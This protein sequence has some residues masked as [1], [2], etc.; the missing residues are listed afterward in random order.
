MS[1]EERGGERGER[2]GRRMEEVMKFVLG[3]HTSVV[4]QQG[5]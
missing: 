3:I 1:E 5:V 2:G 4:C